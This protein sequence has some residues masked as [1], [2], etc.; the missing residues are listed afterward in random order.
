MADDLR[1]VADRN[2]KGRDLAGDDG[3]G[4]DVGPPSDVRSGQHDGVQAEESAVLDSHG[5]GIGHAL[6]EHR[7]SGI[8]VLVV[9]VGD[10]DI[11]GPE[12]VAADGD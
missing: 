5:S 4:A 12:H 9:R 6:P 3:A 7:A 10:E 1:R 8:S 11:V 2:R